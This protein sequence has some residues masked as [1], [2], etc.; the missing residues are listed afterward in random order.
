MGLNTAAASWPTLS[1]LSLAS[2]IA[3]N[4]RWVSGAPSGVSEAAMRRVSAGSRRYAGR[5]P[6]E[7]LV[8]VLT[9]T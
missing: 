5:V 1:S 7:R 9:C 8:Q 3:A 4:H 2:A 6:E